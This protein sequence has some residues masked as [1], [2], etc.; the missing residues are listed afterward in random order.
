VALGLLVLSAGDA[1]AQRGVQ[2]GGPDLRLGLGMVLDFG[3]ELDLD[4]RRWRWDDDL[5]LTPG[6]RVHLD[7][8]IANYVSI[9]GF[10]RASWWEGDEVFE[11][12]NFLFDIG[13]RVTGH[14]EWRD[15]RF[16]AALMVGLTLSNLDD[17]YDYALDDPGVGANVAFVPGAEYWLRDNIGFFVEIFGWSGHFFS[18][19]YERGPGDEDFSL[20]QVAW[21]TGV[22]FGF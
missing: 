6:L 14:Y 18:H 22:V 3:G 12:R 4:Q 10:A 17:D 2:R 8:D 16:Y 19:D 13:A 7:Y 5:K 11:D 20:N 1:H 9:G 15:F 21:Q